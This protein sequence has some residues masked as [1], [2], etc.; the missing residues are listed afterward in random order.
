[1][2]EAG[3]NDDC[4]VLTAEVRKRHPAES[5]HNITRWLV[6]TDERRALALLLS[7]RNRLCKEG[8]RLLGRLAKRAGDWALATRLWEELAA[9]GC[10]DSLERLAIYHEH[11]RKGFTLA[12][13]YCEVLPESDARSHRLARLNRRLHDNFMQSTRLYSAGDDA[14]F[15]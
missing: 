10:T 7:Q 1:M 3:Q 6:E 8:K 14:E 13:H 4:S 15:Y 2:C 9:A 11:I 5:C 12:K